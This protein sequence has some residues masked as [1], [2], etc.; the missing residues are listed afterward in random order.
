MPD[1]LVPIEIRALR[2]Q[3]FGNLPGPPREQMQTW[4]QVLTSNTQASIQGSKRQAIK[5]QQNKEIIRANRPISMFNI[6]TSIERFVFEVLNKVNDPLYFC[7]IVNLTK[8]NLNDHEISLLS[9]G[10]GS[11]HSRSPWHRQYNQWLQWAQEE[12]KIQLIFLRK[13]GAFYFNSQLWWTFPASTA[14]H[15]G[16]QELKNS[17]KHIYKASKSLKCKGEVIIKPVDKGSV[18]V[19]MHKSAYIN[20][21]VGQLSDTH[22]YSEIIV[23]LSGEG[24]QRV[25][26]HLHNMLDRRQITE[27][28]YKDL[29]TNN[30]RIQ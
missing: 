25:N 27:D 11:P 7:G 9:K 8:Y 1:S 2:H 19:I 15:S 20:E 4:A 10:I 3:S 30:E 29:T 26:L 17:I 6:L 24:I 23:D 21:G 5:D 14:L 16:N 13:V 22:F 18:V 28:I 12:G